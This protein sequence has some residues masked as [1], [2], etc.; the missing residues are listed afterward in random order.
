MADISTWQLEYVVEIVSHRG[1][2]SRSF[3]CIAA[4]VWSHHSTCINFR[5]ATTRT[6]W[7][8]NSW[9][10]STWFQIFWRFIR[11]ISWPPCLYLKEDSSSAKAHRSV[12]CLVYFTTEQATD[13]NIKP[14]VIRSRADLH[15]G[16]KH[17]VLTDTHLM[18]LLGRRPVLYG[19]WDS[20]QEEGARRRPL[21][22]CRHLA[23]RPAEMWWWDGASR[24]QIHHYSK[25]TYF[26]ARLR[27]SLALE[28]GAERR[29]WK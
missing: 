14:H 17:G 20:D 23:N 15:L 10:W 5:K 7:D 8:D 18:A 3:H 24:M 12:R 21:H 2:W 4:C 9:S 19:N 26:S 28:Q 13:Y 22:P 1:W 11:L 25:P 6:K 29:E 16:V 27:Q